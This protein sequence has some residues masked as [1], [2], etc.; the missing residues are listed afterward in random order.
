MTR[1]VCAAPRPFLAV[2]AAGLVALAL[3]ACQRPI[4]NAPPPQGPGPDVPGILGGRCT[5]DGFCNDPLIC[6]NDICENDPNNPGEGEGEGEGEGG[7][8]EG[9]GGEGEGEGCIDND[10]D[11]FCADVDCN[12]SDPAIFPTALERCD[13][14]DSNCNGDLNDDLDCTFLAHDRDTTF[15]IDPFELTIT[16]LGDIDISGTGSLLDID[17]DIDG[18]LLAVTRDGIWEVRPN[19]DL[20]SVASITAPDRTNGMAITNT[21]TLFLTN[22]DGGDS[23]AFRVERPSGTLVRVGGFSDGL[24]SSGDCVFTKTGDLLMSA[25]DPD[26]PNASDVLVE[27]NTTTGATTTRGSIGFSRVFGLSDSFG[28]LFGVTQAGEVIELDAAT[29]QGTLLFD[30]DVF[31]NGAANGD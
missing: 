1:P 5:E 6:V 12:D 30:T 3:S 14:I 26:Q 29:G 31:F 8:G 19:G 2:A 16:T 10:N 13:R 22:D 15:A 9:E 25:K 11:G 27:I 28:F 21:G 17:R 18:T 23:A 24:V 20:V 7:E 4:G